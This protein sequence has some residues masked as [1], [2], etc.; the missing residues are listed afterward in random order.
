MSAGRRATGRGSARGARALVL[1]LAFSSLLVVPD[2]AAQDRCALRITAPTRSSVGSPGGE[3]AYTTYLGGGTVTLRCGGAVMTGDSAVRFESEERAEM[4]GDVEYRDATRTL[5]ATRLTYFEPNGQVVASGDVELVRL[6]NRARLTGPR[7]SFFRAGASGAVGRTLATDRP[8]MTM[9]PEGG[10]EPIEIDADEAEFLG[11]TVALARGDVDIRRSDFEATADSARF[12]SETGYLYGRPVVTSG[13]MRITGDSLRVGLAAGGI[14][15]LHAFGDA[16]AEGETVQLE[17]D[18][19]LVIRGQDDVRRIQAYGEG[20]ALAAAG[21]FVLGGDS[22]DVAFTA[23][24]PDSV[25]AVGRARSFQLETLPDSTVPLAEPAAEVSGETSWIEGDTIRAWLGPDGGAAPGA[26]ARIR[27][28]EATGEARSY[29]AAVR[30][31][32]RTTRASRNYILGESIDIRFSDG[33]PSLV[34][35]AQAIGVFLEPGD[36]R[37]GR[38]PA[39]QAENAGGAP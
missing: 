25:I 33:E 35:A 22:L 39:G 24:R 31:T 1:A 17:S 28:L 34:T 2:A 32:A 5:S 9:P 10:G 12:L 14:D 18:E 38:P 11:D 37:D 8:H 6:S 36:G 4:I 15:R 3:G 27:R 26:A 21:E 16:R 20:R 23:G 30:D 19:I 29:F 13:A 7:V